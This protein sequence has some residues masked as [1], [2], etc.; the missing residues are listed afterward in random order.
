MKKILFLTLLMLILASVCL[1]SCFNFGTP[2]NTNTPDDDS[3]TGKSY[4]VTFDSNGGSSVAKQTVVSGKYAKEP[5]APTKSG[6][7]VSG[8]YYGNTRWDFHSD[9]REYD[10]QGKMV[11]RSCKLLAL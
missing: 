5:A 8:W 9:N 3:T 4:T 2:G 6:Y 11:C 10:T 1:T 7:I